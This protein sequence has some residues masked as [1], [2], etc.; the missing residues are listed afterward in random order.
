MRMSWVPL[1]VSRWIVLRYSTRLAGL[2]DVKGRSLTM[3]G[4]RRPVVVVDSSTNILIPFVA[5]CFSSW[6]PEK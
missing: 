3:A 2:G 6:V 4:P 1:R 5:G